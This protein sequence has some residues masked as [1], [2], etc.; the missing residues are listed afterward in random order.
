MF[1]GRTSSGSEEDAARPLSGAGAGAGAG[2]QSVGP[3]KMA[4][5]IGSVVTSLGAIAMFSVIAW[6]LSTSL[7]AGTSTAQ[8]Q[9]LI[10]NPWGIVSLTDL[11][12]GF[13]VFSLWIWFRESSTM[14]AV[15][16]TAVMMTTGW[17][18]GSLYV[19]DCLRQ[20][21]Y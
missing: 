8:V 21:G 18:G 5:K 9:W 6:A 17:L 16:W 11:Y 1:D 15:V 12:T 14:A 2:W 7:A 19:L 13:T 3:G 10:S 4:S 20:D